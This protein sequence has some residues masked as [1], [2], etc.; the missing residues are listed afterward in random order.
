MEFP[1]PKK[2]G[3]F[4]SFKQQ[5]VSSAG[6]AAAAEMLTKALTAHI[7]ISSLPCFPKRTSAMPKLN[8]ILTCY[9]SI[10]YSAFQHV[11]VLKRF[12]PLNALCISTE[13]TAGRLV[14]LE[15]PINSFQ[16]CI[17]KM[18]SIVFQLPG[19]GRMLNSIF[20]TR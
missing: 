9:S 1:L 6:G 11:D 10:S 7:L 16:F 4:F 3:G 13:R 14:I 2:Q 17:C 15:P 19:L 18:Q 20:I 5:L 8:P 12:C